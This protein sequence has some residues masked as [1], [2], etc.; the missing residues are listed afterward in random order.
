M[1]GTVGEVGHRVQKRVEVEQNLDPGRVQIQ[2]L[3]MAVN[4]VQVLQEID[5]PVIQ[6]DVQVC[7][8]SFIHPIVLQSI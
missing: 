6:K 4:L 1:D 3:L 5:Q 8:N 7:C 2:V